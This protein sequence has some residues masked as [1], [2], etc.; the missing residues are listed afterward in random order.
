MPSFPRTL[1]TVVPS[2]TSSPM[3]SVPAPPPTPRLLSFASALQGS[4]PSLNQLKALGTEGQ[5]KLV[6]GAWDLELI[7]LIREWQAEEQPSKWGSGAQSV[8]ARGSTLLGAG[9]QVTRTVGRRRCRGEIKRPLVHALAGVQRA[10]LD[11]VLSVCTLPSG[12]QGLSSEEALN[13]FSLTGTLPSATSRLWPQL[14][15]EAST[16]K[17]SQWLGS[18]HHSGRER[19]EIKARGQAEMSPETRIPAG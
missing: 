3:A 7:A 14:G 6:S 12:G 2:P 16:G 5:R 15:R 8:I 4:P 9:P 10:A 18:P 19:R 17:W 1:E 13:K 11:A